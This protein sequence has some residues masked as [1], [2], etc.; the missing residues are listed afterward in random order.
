MDLLRSYDSDETSSDD[1]EYVREPLGEKEVRAVYMLMYS[2]ANLDLFPSRE[3]FA[4]AVIRSFSN[5]TAKILHW[6][7]CR[8]KH[9]KSG[10]HYHLAL[11]LDRNQRWL[12]SK[13]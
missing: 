1:S 12:S 3:D 9:K 4:S 7:C 10:E 13:N 6:C 11:K 5:G 2:Q 8:E